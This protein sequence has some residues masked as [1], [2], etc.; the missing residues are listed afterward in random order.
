M[1][2]DANTIFDWTITSGD[3]Y[4]KHCDLALSGASVRRWRVHVW[5]LAPRIQHSLA[6]TKPLIVEADKAA[7]ELKDYYEKHVLDVSRVGK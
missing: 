1:R 7:Q 3:L 4:K 5:D 2:L 6:L